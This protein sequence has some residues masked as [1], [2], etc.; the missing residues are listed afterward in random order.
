[1]VLASTPNEIG[2]A[3]GGE[4][5]RETVELRPSA[6]RG[7]PVGDVPDDDGI[8]NRGHTPRLAE[9]PWA[10]PCVGKLSDL[11]KLRIELPYGVIGGV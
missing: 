1:M 8:A 7:A 2:A 4:S 9:L 11:P 5:K 3:H 10:V 6:L